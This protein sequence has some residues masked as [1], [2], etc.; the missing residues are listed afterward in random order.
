MN[1]IVVPILSKCLP[2]MKT[3]KLVLILQLLFL[4]LYVASGADVPASGKW[5][6]PQKQSQWLEQIEPMRALKDY[7]PYEIGAVL[8]VQKTV[9]PDDLKRALG[10][11]VNLRNC[12]N[13]FQPELGFDPA[14]LKNTIAFF[15]EIYDESDAVVKAAKNKGGTKDHPA[16][17]RPFV[18]DS[19]VQCL[20]TPD[21]ASYLRLNSSFPSGHS[22]EGMLCSLILCDVLAECPSIKDS[23][24][25]YRAAVLKHGCQFGDDR[26]LLGV[27]YPSD[28]IAGRTLAIVLYNQIKSNPLYSKTVKSLAMDEMDPALKLA[29]AKSK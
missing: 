5:L 16:R 10:E 12:L 25:S 27:H 4:S 20:D 11:A 13:K 26:V 21:N 19:R 9:S 2:K 3:L 24:P 15:L 14:P 8:Q 23:Y 22:M 28:V 7:D 17:N 6:D 18:E 29:T 1:L